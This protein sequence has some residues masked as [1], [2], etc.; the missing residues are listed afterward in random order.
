MR[1]R[2]V[3]LFA[4]FCL[5]Q[6]PLYLYLGQGP[7]G[8]DGA[9]KAAESGLQKLPTSPQEQAR[10]QLS[11]QQAAEALAQMKVDDSR[12]ARLDL[13]RA[14]LAWTRGDVAEA[15]SRFRAALTQLQ[16]TH[17]PDAFFTAVVS[18]RYAEFLM[19]N[20]RLDDALAHFEAG[21]GPVDDT[22]GPGSPFAVRMRFRRIALLTQLG[23]NPEAM[24]QADQYLP[25]L[26]DQAGRF[27]EA[28][29][30][31][32]ASALEILERGE[33]GVPPAPGGRGWRAA[34]RQAHLD[35]KA[36]LAKEPEDG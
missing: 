11:L 4:L 34:L 25:S 33:P 29:L 1:D 16:A 2:W 20:Q 31:Q 26:L 17:G 7:L 23:R 27:D 12:L 35:G 5:A 9:I 14:M 32:T 8:F 24:A 3:I 6:L 13:S 19:L 22:M 28:F 10:I 30:M 18:C 36:R 15:D 21:L